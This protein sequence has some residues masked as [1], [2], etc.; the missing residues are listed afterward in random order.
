[1]NDIASTNS[2]PYTLV[3]Q[4]FVFILH[5]PAIK[6]L[7][8]SWHQALSNP[9]N[10]H[11]GLAFAID[12]AQSLYWL[13]FTDLL[14][15]SVSL[16]TKTIDLWP[17]V[18]LSTETLK[19]ILIDQLVPRI[20]AAQDALVLH[21]GSVVVGES[22]I[23]LMGDTGAG[24]STLT[25]S[26]YSQGATLVNDDAVVV[27]TKHDQ[28]F[29]S[30]SHPSLR[31]LPDSMRKLLI[32]SAVSLP[33]SQFTD[34]R[35]VVIA[36]GKRH[37]NPDF[38]LAA[39]FFIGKEPTEQISLRLLPPAQAVMTIIANSFALNPTDIESATANFYRACDLAE[40][41][42]AFELNYPRSYELL[43][44]VHQ[45]IFNKLEELRA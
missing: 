28:F 21:A 27:S 14:T 39:L 8:P 30:A 12:Q 44:D 37:A 13:R 16:I 41:V 35:H 25:A 7:P 40:N 15:I 23:A 2:F 20:L 31:L 29:V 42:P 26:F 38:P 5:D 17:D 18:S 45:A 33:I 3:D 36:N 43:G 10:W 11:G 4:G 32:D 19:R 6:H 34:K 24:K 9:I 22:A 1:M